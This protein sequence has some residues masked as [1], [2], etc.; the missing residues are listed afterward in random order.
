MQGVT[1]WQRPQ[2]T[3]ELAHD[4]VPA[5]DRIEYQ[6]GVVS[7]REGRLLARNTGPQHSARLASLVGANALLILP[8]RPTPYR[9][10]ERVQAL[11]LDS[12]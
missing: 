9:A 11:L 10:G 2:V 1:A 6:R 4:I 5:E 12:A 8:P 7:A 3:V